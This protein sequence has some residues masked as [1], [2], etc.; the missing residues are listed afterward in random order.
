MSGGK[1]YGM[2]A[3]AAVAILMGSASAIAAK[4]DVNA[5]R[6]DGST[7]LQWAAFNDDVAEAKRLIAAG[8]DVKLKNNYGISPMLLAADIASTDMIQL[9]LRKGA[10]AN[11]IHTC[12]PIGIAAPAHDGASEEDGGE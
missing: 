10:D 7:P 9:L 8:A 11:L 12:G 5:R 3:A 1:K 4:E 6:V 2:A